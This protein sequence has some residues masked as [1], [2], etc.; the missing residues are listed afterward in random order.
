VNYCPG[1]DKDF[2]SVGAFDAHRVGDFPQ[3]GPAQYTGPIN[4]WTPKSGR[5]CLTDAE[6]LQRGWT[7]DGRGRWRRPGDG[8]PWARS[9][10]QAIAQR[11]RKRLP[12][13]SGHPTPRRGSP[14]LPDS[15]SEAAR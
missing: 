7:R 9:Q 13:D 8:A 10:D 4:V 12:R 1:C 6:L 14:S 15:H 3:T 2:G 11:R 5:R